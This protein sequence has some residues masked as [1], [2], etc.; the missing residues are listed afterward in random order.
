MSEAAMKDAE[1]CAHYLSELRDDEERERFQA[2]VD[3]FLIRHKDEMSARTL[4]VHLADAYLRAVPHD[5][6]GYE[7]ILTWATQ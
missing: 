1:D 7:R 3:D 6:S 2:A 4:R 5:V